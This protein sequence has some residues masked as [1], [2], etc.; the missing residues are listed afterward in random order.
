M[1]VYNRR[2]Y[3]R[4]REYWRRY[5]DEHREK[6]QAYQREYQ[7][8]YRK[9][10]GGTEKP[11]KAKKPCTP[12]TMFRNKRDWEAYK[13]LARCV[14]DKRKVKLTKQESEVEHEGID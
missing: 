7:R 13:A 3:D 5:Y 11:R 8:A 6:I 2:R 4:N 1:K 14:E 9:R 12:R 10:Q